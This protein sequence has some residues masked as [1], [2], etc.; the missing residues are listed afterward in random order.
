LSHVAAAF[1]TLSAIFALKRTIAQNSDK[2][3][4]PAGRFDK[5]VSNILEKLQRLQIRFLGDTACTATR[6]RCENR[7][8]QAFPF[9]NGI[10]MQRQRMHGVD[11]SSVKRAVDH[12]VTIQKTLAVKRSLTNTTLK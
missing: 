3:K 10:G 9:F 11:S 7:I 8:L 12:T 5:S 4:R 2:T 1:F 6:R